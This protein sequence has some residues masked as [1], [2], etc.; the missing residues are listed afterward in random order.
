MAGGSG[1]LAPGSVLVGGGLPPPQVSAAPQSLISTIGRPPALGA[2]EAAFVE[3]GQAARLVRCPGALA[4]ASAMDSPV[5]NPGPWKA[6]YFLV[7]S[8]MQ[9]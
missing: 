6:P 4:T 7:H 8:G 2:T 9:L 5:C 3:A 1:G